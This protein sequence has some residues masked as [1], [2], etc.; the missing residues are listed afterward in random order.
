MVGAAARG[1]T[2]LLSSDARVE[3]E[4]GDGQHEASG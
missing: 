3:Q 4:P 1:W 2:A